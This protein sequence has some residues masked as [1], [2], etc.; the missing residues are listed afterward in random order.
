MRIIIRQIIQ[1]QNF[2]VKIVAKSE[3]KKRAADV[4][5][6]NIEDELR[7]RIIVEVD[8]RSKRISSTNSD[9]GEIAYHVF[10]REENSIHIL[11]KE[12]AYDVRYNIKDILVEVFEED[13]L[14][15]KRYIY[16]DGASVDESVNIEYEQG[17]YS[18]VIYTYEGLE[19]IKDFDMNAKQ[20]IK[21]TVTDF[22]DNKIEKERE[23]W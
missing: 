23:F 15:R 1:K 17:K 11:G 16:K 14:L 3:E 9:E 12:F 8:L 20:R 2:D 22:Y 6:I 19:Q 18:R 7:D 13:K 4:T 21:V 5:K 10:I